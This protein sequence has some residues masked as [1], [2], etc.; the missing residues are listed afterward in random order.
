MVNTGEIVLPEIQ[1]PFVWNSTQVRDFIDSLYRGYP[2]G[3]LIV[4]QNPNVKA[5]DGTMAK[6]KKILIDG[7]QRITTLMT[8]IL[9]KEEG[10]F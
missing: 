6:G 2:V 3:Y 8:S 4:G 7:Q 5:K 9:G 10:I 1:R